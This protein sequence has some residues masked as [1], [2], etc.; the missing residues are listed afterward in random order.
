MKE[1]RNEHLERAKREVIGPNTT[2]PWSRAIRVDEDGAIKK[3]GEEA[4]RI[5]EIEVKL[6]EEDKLKRPLITAFKKTP[7]SGDELNADM[8]SS[9]TGNPAFQSGEDVIEKP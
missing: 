9:F 4:R 6:Q 3:A 7:L 1:I 8:P 5:N 2:V